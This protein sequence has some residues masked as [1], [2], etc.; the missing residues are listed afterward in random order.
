MSPWLSANQSC[1]FMTSDGIKMTCMYEIA[2]TNTV[3]WKGKKR[4]S[5][6]R[7]VSLT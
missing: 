7:P 4:S 1:I 2:S 3:K 5:L 6:I